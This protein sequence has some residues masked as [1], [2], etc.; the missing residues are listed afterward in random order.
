MRSMIV[1]ELMIGI[2]QLINNN[3]AV[4]IFAAIAVSSYVRQIAMDLFVTA[5]VENSH[6]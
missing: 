1:V 5:G 4:S 3:A 6:G 2:L